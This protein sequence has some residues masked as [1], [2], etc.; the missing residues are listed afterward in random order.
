MKIIVITSPAEVKEEGEAIGR[1]LDSGVVERI[2]LRKPG[3]DE[4]ETRRLIESIPRCHYPR[5]SL[6]DHHNLACEYGLGGIHLNNR[7]P[8]LPADP[9]GHIVS[10]SCHS[11][12]EVANALTAE[13]TGYCFL[14]PVFDSVSK[15]G[16]RGRITP[17]DCRDLS[18]AGLLDGRIF[19][20]AGITPENLREVKALGFHGAAILGAAWEDISID[21]FINRLKQNL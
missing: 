20:L 15:P 9:E 19:A 16:Y 18:S 12:A 21:N 10:R 1:L 17:E 13:R 5:L 14:S 3:L 4:M 11:V 2:H 7:N 8:S 6:H